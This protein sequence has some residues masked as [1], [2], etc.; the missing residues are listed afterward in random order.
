M[1][2]L[3]EIYR[4]EHPVLQSGPFQAPSVLHNLQYREF[5][6]SKALGLAVEQFFKT[7]P[8]VN[9]SKLTS[10]TLASPAITAFFTL[11]LELCELIKGVPSPSEDNLASVPHYYVYGFANKELLDAY[12]QPWLPAVK[13]LKLLGFEL[14][15][16]QVP[17]KHVRRS[18]SGMQYAFSSDDVV[19]K[20][21]LPF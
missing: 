10:S 5:L 3:I 14:L 7:N 2:N 17:A 8:V 21:V 12:L 13:R 9:K 6:E 1:A 20:T 19:S 16:L 18:T 4:I 11:S 15:K